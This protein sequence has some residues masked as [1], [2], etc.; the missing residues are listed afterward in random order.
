MN[1]NAS[2]QYLGD[3]AAKFNPQV[4]D[5]SHSAL[6]QL[7]NQHHQANHGHTSQPTHAAGHHHPT[8]AAGHNIIHG[9]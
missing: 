4:E 7:P 8:H 9:A 2:E 6:D 1:Y 5:R 3:M